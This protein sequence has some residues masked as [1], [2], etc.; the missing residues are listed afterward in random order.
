MLEFL[1]S[2]SSES[3]IARHQ[4]MPEEVHEAAQRPYHTYPGREDTTILLGRTIAGRY[5]FVVLAE[6]ED[7]RKFVVTAREMTA[8]ERR[9]YQRKAR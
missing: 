4:V 5:L 2:D 6:A 7:G 1:W 9:E 3:H 8:P